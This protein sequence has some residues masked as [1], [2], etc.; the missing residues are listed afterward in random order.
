MAVNAEEVFALDSSVRYVATNQGGEIELTQNPKWPSH[1]PGD[2]DRMEEL[3]VNPVVIELARRRGDLDLEGV[4]Y[5]AI[6]YGLQ[7]QLLFPYADGHLSVGVEHAADLEGVAAK[8]A[9]HLGLPL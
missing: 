3:I 2:T 7:W 1:N 4:R 6:R 8:V 5:V 9:E